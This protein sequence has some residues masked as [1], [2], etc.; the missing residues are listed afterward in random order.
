LLPNL[1][2]GSHLL[3]FSQW[4]QYI[5]ARLLAW[6]FLCV[7]ESRKFMIFFIIILKMPFN[8]VPVYCNCWSA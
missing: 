2:L 7:H 8:P 5:F 3:V 6:M 4:F 1:W